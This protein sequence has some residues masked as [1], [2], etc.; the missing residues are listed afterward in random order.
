VLEGDSRPTDAD[1]DEIFAN[2]P[3]KPQPLTESQ[4]AERR[5]Q[6]DEMLKNAGINTSGWS[7]A[8]DAVKGTAKGLLGGIERLGAGATF[9]LT[10]WVGD[11]LGTGVKERRQELEDMNGAINGL[12][13]GLDIVGGI[14]S[15]G[16]LFKGVAGGLKAIP[17]VGKVAQYLAPT[18]TG[19]VSG[20]LYGGFE[21]DSLE[22][23][24]T[25]AIVG[26]ALGGALDLAGR[27]VSKAFS[28]AQKVKGTPRGFENAAGTKTGSRV[29][30]RAVK[31]SDKIA[32]EVYRKAPEAMENLNRQA[33]DKLDDAV[34]GVDVKG[35]VA[36]A[37]KAYGDYIEENKAKQ[38]IEGK[39][40]PEEYKKN[41]QKWFRGS[42][43]VD[44]SGNPLKLYHGTDA[45][46]D[47]FKNNPKSIM[48]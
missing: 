27:G 28:A 39:F 46:F 5:Q 35:Q 33:I 34:R 21:N 16:A 17:K 40:T 22:S 43:V 12:N 38:I 9:G 29:L 37:K 13:V 7:V 47:V 41:L 4:L 42:K 19:A 32:E 31:E 15:G 45:E 44:D 23:A 20:G 26:G 36:G 11:K 25:G 3:Q 2:L 10:D 8:G 14:P 48:D 6:A 30:N 24:G 1:L 18:A